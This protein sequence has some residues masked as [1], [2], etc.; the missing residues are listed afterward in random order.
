MNTNVDIQ[1]IESAA[2]DLISETGVSQNVF[3]GFRPR[4]YDT[5]DDLVVV[6]VSGGSTDE[7]ALGKSALSIELYTKN[8]GMIRD[9]GKLSE[10]W[11]KIRKAMTTV[12]GP[13]LYSYL[14][15]TPSID[16]GNGFSFEIVNYTIII[17]RGD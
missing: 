7:L 12:S 8:V 2:F 14:N 6:R 9:S 17:K 15:T 16:D 13:Y 1:K 5:M 10:M 4:A 3:V 11:A